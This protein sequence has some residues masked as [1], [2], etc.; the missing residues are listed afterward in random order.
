MS[1]PIL[2]P[3]AFQLNPQGL[4]CASVLTR[5]PWDPSHQHAGP[6]IALACRAL[7]QAG[8]AH[9]LTHL[10]R[11]TANLIRPVPIDTLDVEVAADYLGKSA[12]HFNAQIT[13]QGKLCVRLTALLQREQPLTVPPDRPGHPLPLAP[14][15]WQESPEVSMPF[16][17]PQRLGYGDLVDS[18]VAEGRMFH[19]PSTVWFRLAYPLVAGETPTGYQRV[20]V[21]ADS[22]NGISAALDLQRFTFVNSDLTVNLLRKPQGEWICLQARSLLGGNGCGLAESTLFDE[23]GLIGRATQSLVVRERAQR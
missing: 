15:P 2:P 21:A 3:A 6:P 22:G 18:R 5:G 7:E 12:G 20:M 23:A 13:A 4:A 19:G 10:A 14:R 1:T 11:L 9:G 8:A 17:H 16:R